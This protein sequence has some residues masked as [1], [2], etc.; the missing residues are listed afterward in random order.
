MPQA[1]VGIERTRGA[2]EPVLTFVVLIV[3]FLCSGTLTFAHAGAPKSRHYSDD[4]LSIDISG[5]EADVISALQEVLAEPDI[6]GTNSYEKDKVLK[7]AK[8]ADKT[9]I[10]E[11]WTEGGHVFYKVAQD[12]LA[13]RH[14]K[15]TGDIGTVAVRYII[16]PVDPHTTHIRI[17]AA[18]LETARRELHP[19]DGSVEI[20]EFGVIREHLDKLVAR[21]NAPPISPSESS[22]TIAE[23]APVH[24]AVTSSLTPRPAAPIAPPVAAVAEGP[25]LGDLEAKVTALR[26]QVEAQITASDAHLKAAPYK[27]AANVVSLPPQTQVVVL[28][29]TKYWFGVETADGHH[30]WLP[31]T[32]VEFV[33]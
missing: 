20:A 14:F 18:F 33:Q 27:S 9:T 3:L 16:Q 8:T 11:P 2:R 15:D 23:P 24:P 10:F 12:V 1:L 21:R 29:V 17:D 28:I 32:Q 31:R 25:S 19:S 26:R 7:G 13:P 4:P 5:S 6:H 30:G 22:S